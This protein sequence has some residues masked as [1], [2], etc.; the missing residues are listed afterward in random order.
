MKPKQE[1][2]T[3]HEQIEGL[4]LAEN[5]YVL[6]IAIHGEHIMLKHPIALS[7]TARGI[8]WALHPMVLRPGGIASITVQ[9]HNPGMVYVAAMLSNHNW[10]LGAYRNLVVPRRAICGKG[11]I[12]DMV[13]KLGT[14]EM[15]LDIDRWWA[16]VWV[17]PLSNRRCQSCSTT[18]QPGCEPCNYSARACPLWTVF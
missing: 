2:M 7:A 11:T 1:L 9:N 18:D 8:P 17:P 4:A 16:S 5:V 12:I 13:A 10:G 3:N 6:D 14:D 15:A